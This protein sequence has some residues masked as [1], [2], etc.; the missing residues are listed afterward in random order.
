VNRLVGEVEADITHR[1]LLPDG[2]TV[3]VAVSGGV[4]SVVLLEIL[5]RLSARHRWNLIVAHFNH[6]L[7]GKQSDGDERFVRLLSR[8]LG[9]RCVV[10]RERVARRAQRGGVSV[11]MAGRDARHAFLAATAR[12][13]HAH[14]VALAHH[15]DDQVELFLLRLLRGA[16]AEGLGGMPWSS[17][18]PVDSQV[19]LVRPLLRRCKEELLD[20]ARAWSVSF[21][22]DQTN[23]STNILRN[24]IRHEL[25]PL[26]CRRYQPGL[27]EVILRQAELCAA[28]AEFLSR[29]ARHWMSSR[30]PAFAELATSLQRRVVLEQ[31]LELG[32]HPEFEK[33]ESLRRKAGHPVQVGDGVVVRRCPDGTI[34]RE[35][36]ARTKGPVEVSERPI[37]SVKLSGGSGKIHFGR[38]RIEWLIRKGQPPAVNRRKPGLEWFDADKVGAAVQLRTRRPGDRFQPSGMPEPCKLQDLLTNARIA[39][40]RRDEL[41]VAMNSGGTIWWV[42]GLRI[43]EACKV[44][45]ATRRFLRWKWLLK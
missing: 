2:Q 16:S 1:G 37:L 21:R 43:G 27:F 10:A 8:R 32:I 11:E 24:R 35:T 18:S 5:H 15:A 33:V 39:R 34:E 20:F 25:L 38:Y 12:E 45:L 19:R 44:G 17:V 23:D 40:A 36:A 13:Q 9:L 4:D 7:R 22:R 14:C 26:L 29:E 31:L 42:D 30:R 28:D 41:A 3:L 6:Q